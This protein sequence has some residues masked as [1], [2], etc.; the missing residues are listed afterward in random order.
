MVVEEVVELTG[1]WRYLVV[2][3]VVVELEEEVGTPSGGYQ[4]QYS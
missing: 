4:Q 1:N 2:E 3:L